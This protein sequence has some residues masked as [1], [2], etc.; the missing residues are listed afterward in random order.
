V[1]PRPALSLSKG[2]RCAH[3]IPHLPSAWQPVPIGVIVLCDVRDDGLHFQDVGVAHV[4]AGGEV[5]GVGVAGL[6]VVGGV[7]SLTFRRERLP[8]LLVLPH[9]QEAGAGIYAG[10]AIFNIPGDEHVALHHRFE[11]EGGRRGV[12]NH[13]KVHTALAAY[14]ILQGHGVGATGTLPLRARYI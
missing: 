2:G 5:E 4:V 12:A 6:A 14:A 10:A 11:G 1:E 7:F 9:L 3:S 13:A 8:G